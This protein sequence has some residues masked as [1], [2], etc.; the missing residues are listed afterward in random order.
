VQVWCFVVVCVCVCVCVRMIKFDLLLSFL[1]LFRPIGARS[2]RSG[3][4]VA[5]RR[6]IRFVVNK[7]RALILGWPDMR[8][9]QASV[10]K[11]TRPLINESKKGSP[12]ARMR[13]STVP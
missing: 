3:V 10:R 12:T 7:E 6:L 9:R 5:S 8:T 2:Q 1:K 4:L 13:I 11:L